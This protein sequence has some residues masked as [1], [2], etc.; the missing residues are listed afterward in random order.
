MP[1]N[2]LLKATLEQE[3]LA[4]LEAREELLL[5]VQL[6][7]ADMRT[8]WNRID[9]ALSTVRAEVTRLDTQPGS[10]SAET[11]AMARRLL[12]EVK[13]HIASLQRRHWPVRPTS[14]S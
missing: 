2:E 9:D 6:D 10:A 12:D 8:Q 5:E 3:L 14:P 1:E 4:L 11:A 13:A 7:H